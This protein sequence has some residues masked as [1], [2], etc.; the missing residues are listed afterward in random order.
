MLPTANQVFLAYKFVVEIDENV[1]KTVFNTISDNKE[2]FKEKDYIKVV[3]SHPDLMSWLTK[4][5]EI[6]E[7]KLEQN[8]HFKEQ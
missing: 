2:Y 5:K 3:R 6:L 4:P 8:A 7:G 1:I